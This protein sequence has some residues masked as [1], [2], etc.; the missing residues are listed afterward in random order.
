MRQQQQQQQQL[1]LCAL[2]GIYSPQQGEAPLAWELPA[3]QA[4]SPGQHL[5]EGT[6]EASRSRGEVRSMLYEVHLQAAHVA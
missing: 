5:L 3:P 1:L 2:A 6:G 4:G